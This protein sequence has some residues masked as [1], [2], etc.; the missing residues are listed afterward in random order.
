[1]EL[2]FSRVIPFVIKLAFSLWFITFLIFVAGFV[3]KK[4]KSSINNSDI[5]Q[6]AYNERLAE[7]M[8]AVSYRWMLTFAIMIFFQ[9]MWINIGFLITGLTFGIGFAFKE[10]LGNM[11]AGLMILTNKKFAIGDIVQFE[12]GLSYFGRIIEISI[13][14][15][16]VQTF[17]QRKVI[18]PN[19][20]LVSNFVKTFSAEQ[21][22]KVNIDIDI[23]FQDDPQSACEIIKNYLN[24]KDFILEK[25]STKVI[26]SSIFHSWYTLTMFF[27]MKPKG[28]Q[29]L[30]VAKSLI[31]QELLGFFDTQWRNYPWDHIAITTD[32]LDE[33]LID[34]LSSM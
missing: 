4:I 16:I 29:W 7:L 24:E 32:R 18:I 28:K 11:F 5:T 23:G 15:T 8:S 1:M 9:M 17:D 25:Q 12:G 10:I 14:H 2:N 20:M 26:V 19:T 21:I 31:K 30:F 22:I 3:S 6:S 13:R 33:N 34:T 27:Y